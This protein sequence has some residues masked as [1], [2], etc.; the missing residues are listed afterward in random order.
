MINDTLYV[1]RNQQRSTKTANARIIITTPTGGIPFNSSKRLLITLIGMHNPIITQ[2][3]LEMMK[4][5]EVHALNSFISISRNRATAYPIS[6]KPKPRIAQRNVTIHR[7]TIVP[8]KVSCS[9]SSG[10]SIGKSDI[11]IPFNNKST[12]QR[13]STQK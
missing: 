13:I 6:T 10:K 4:Y 11:F 9:C 1:I 7:N 3:P 5:A 12:L 8:K 2:S